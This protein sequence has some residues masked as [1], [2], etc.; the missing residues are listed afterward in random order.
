[1]VWPEGR[2]S[3]GSTQGGRLLI[4]LG[5]QQAPEEIAVVKILLHLPPMTMHGSWHCGGNQKVCCKRVNPHF[6]WKHR[7]TILDIFVEILLFYS[8]SPQ[9][10]IERQ[11]EKKKR[12][13]ERERSLENLPMAADCTVYKSL[14]PNAD[15]LALRTRAPAVTAPLPLIALW[16]FLFWTFYTNEIRHYVVFCVWFLLLIIFSRLRHVVAWI[17]PRFL[18]MAE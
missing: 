10:E 14:A 3:W 11:R 2:C 17:N 4:Q 13:R 18:L 5:T 8:G 1:M 9:Q 6:S 15:P 16:I 7:D 12:E